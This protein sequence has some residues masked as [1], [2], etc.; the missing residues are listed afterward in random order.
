MVSD[1]I[2]IRAATI[3]D[4]PDLVRLRRM[5]FE[6]MG[7]DD[8][9]Q[10]DTA[11]AA[12]S[13]YLAQ[14]MPAK[15]FYGWLAVTHT[16]EA[17]GSG[18]VVFD[19]HPPGPTNVSG[20]IGYIMNLVTDPRYRRRGIARHMMQTMIEWLAEQGIQRVTLHATDVGRPLYKELGFVDSNEMRLRL[21]LEHI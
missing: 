16:G 18:G 9:A 2:T 1:E 11:D 3:Q 21:E 17:V 15:E 10:M 5:M 7:F 19:Q 6:S 20:R 14:A 4:I 12:A 13:A 8:P